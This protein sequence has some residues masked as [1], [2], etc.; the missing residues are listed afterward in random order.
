MA[1][2]LERLAATASYAIALRRFLARTLTPEEA[3]ARVER[4][5]AQRDAIFLSTLER[6]VYA[7]PT[8]PYLRLLR[9]AGIELDDVRALVASVGLEGALGRLYDA[10]VFLSQAEAKARRPVRRGSLE[11]E[12][13]EAE[14]ANPLADEHFEATTSGSRGTPTRVFVGFDLVAGDAPY[15]SLLGEAHGL[16]GRPYAYWHPALY[17]AL[18]TTFKHALTGRWPEKWWTPTRFNWGLDS[19]RRQYVVAVTLLVC[20]ALR[21][22]L[23]RPQYVPR[24]EVMLVTRWLA[25]KAR[26]GQPALL[27]T[28][29]SVAVR[30]CLAAREYGLEIGGTLFHCTGEPYTPAKAAVVTAAGASLI[31]RYANSETGVLAVACGAPDGFDDL[32]LVSDKL[33]LIQRE[34]PLPDTGG[35]VNALVFTTIAPTAPQLWLNVENGDYATAT[36]RDCGCPLGQAGLSIHLRG[37]RAI[38]KLTSEGVTFLGDDLYN[39]LERVLPARFG[40]GPTDYQ[41]VE[42]EVGG[43]PKVS[44]VV[45]PSVGGVDA[46]EVLGAVYETLRAAPGGGL[47]VAEWQ[48]GDTLQVVRRD[49]FE[50]HTAKILPLYILPRGETADPAAR[51]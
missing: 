20:R 35:P 22:P 6:G 19:L 4:G 27:E 24:G 36:K 17:T 49:P 10:G 44:L 23:P 43:L 5:L 48:Q 28:N 41:L 14:L 12:L 34:K 50:T 32:H 8:S 30:V 37:V 7:Q 1:K 15:Y 40:G 46:S 51:P 42:E 26:S 13:R 16:A 9:H 31:D 33:A 39:L 47:M 38:D 18:K 21:K 25:E 11:F 2:S 3:R 45:R 29:H